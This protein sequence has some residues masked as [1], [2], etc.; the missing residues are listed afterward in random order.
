[1]HERDSKY[2]N[3]RIWLNKPFWSAYLKCPIKQEMYTSDTV[4][5][6]FQVLS[7]LKMPFSAPALLK[8]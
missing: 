7:V 3:E 2:F 8:S 1:M 4:I 6:T 5:A